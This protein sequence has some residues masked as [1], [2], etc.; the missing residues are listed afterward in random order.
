MFVDGAA[1]EAN[2]G[3]EPVEA[4]SAAAISNLLSSET[5]TTIA[6]AATFSS[7]HSLYPA[8]AEANM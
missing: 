1:F 7:F 3:E 8:R 2:E 5:P 6:N 4:V